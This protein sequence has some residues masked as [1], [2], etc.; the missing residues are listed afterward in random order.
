[1]NGRNIPGVGFPK[2][3]PLPTFFLMGF[4]KFIYLFLVVLGLRC[5]RGVSSSSVHGLLIAV[6]SLV[7]EHGAS[8]VVVYGLNRCSSWAL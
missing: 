1:M 8:V 3:R 7:A 4:L 2:I 6:A 5:F